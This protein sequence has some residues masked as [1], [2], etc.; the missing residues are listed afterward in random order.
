MKARYDNLA[1]E[2]TAALTREE[3]L[4]AKFE[5]LRAELLE[6]D[7]ALAQVENELFATQQELGDKQS[8]QDA[9]QQEAIQKAIS[10]AKAMKAQRDVMAEDLRQKSEELIAANEHCAVS[11]SMLEALR[12]DMASRLEEKDR[13]IEHLDRHKLT[14]DQLEKINKVKQDRT[15]LQED[16]KVMKKQLVELKQAFDTFKAAQASKIAA[17]AGASVA[18]MT[19]ELDEAKSQL[20]SS[21]SI[22]TTMKEKLT[23]CSIQ[24]QVWYERPKCLLTKLWI[25]S[26]G[27]C[28]IFRGCLLFVIIYHLLFAVAVIA[29]GARDG[30]KRS[31][32]GAESPRH[33]HGKPS[34]GEHLQLRDRLRRISLSQLS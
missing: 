17:S 11:E 8:S 26:F 4:S 1:E 12:S 2:L 15:R 24:I 21:R 19:Q 34:R 32:R 22:I 7:D 16:N 10:A 23:R 31:H 14:K 27:I 18:A 3:A 30:E 33:R 9:E 29:V 20:E 13:R 5:Q 6:K 25:L 28:F